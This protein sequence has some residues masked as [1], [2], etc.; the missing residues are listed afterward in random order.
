[1]A[2]LGKLVKQAEKMKRGIESL[3]AQLEEERK[4]AESYYGSWQRS[5]A[6]FAN[7][8]RR[9]EQERADAAKMYPPPGK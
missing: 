3:Q 4:K 6:D 2:G 9:T 1:M 8:R 5:A 7:F